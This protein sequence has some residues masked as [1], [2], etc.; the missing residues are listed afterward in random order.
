MLTKVFKK[1]SIKEGLVLNEK[2]AN[3]DILHI[4]SGKFL[5]KRA[6]IH[7]GSGFNVYIEN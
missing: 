4:L 6:C 5:N 3:F 1:K 2:S 7:L